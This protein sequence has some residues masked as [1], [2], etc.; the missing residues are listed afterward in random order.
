VRRHVSPQTGRALEMLGHAIE[1]LADE[2]S[3][4]CKSPSAHDGPL[5]AVQLLMR[6]N[7]EIYL[8]CPEVRTFADRW[9]WLLRLLAV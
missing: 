5:D 7:R 9:R 2:Y 3:H 6:I 4:Q 8:E 1:Y